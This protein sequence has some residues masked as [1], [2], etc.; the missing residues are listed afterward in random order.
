MNQTAS[1]QHV[2]HV[3]RDAVTRAI[4]VV[5]LAGMALIHAIDAPSHLTG[6]PDTYLGLMFIGLIL[7]SL[8]LAGGLIHRG[9]RRLWA[10]TCG[11]ATTAVIGFCLSRTT[12]LPAD[13]GDIGNWSEPLGIASLFVEISLLALSAAV[14]RGLLATAAPVAVRDERAAGGLRS[15]AVPL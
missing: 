8:A 15:A 11:L 10:A 6:G 13:S 4:G 1:D 5:G 7:T 14:A 12:G 9:D 3:I 2:R